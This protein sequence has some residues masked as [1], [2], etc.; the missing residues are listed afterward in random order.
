MI[1]K[2]WNWTKDDDTRFLTLRATL[3]QADKLGPAVVQLSMIVERLE[4][5]R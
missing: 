1:E 3:R 2:Q 4:T 5:G